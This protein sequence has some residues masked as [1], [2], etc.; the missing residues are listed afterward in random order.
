MRDAALMIASLGD[1]FT[2]SPAERLVAALRGAVT[3]LRRARLARR[4][5]GHLRRL[6][7]RL[8]DDLGLAPADLAA[9]DPELSALDATRRLAGAAAR[10]NAARRAEERWG[11]I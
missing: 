4:H 3:W 10:R 2:A 8:L 11:R 5:L 7:A 1:D 6:D 9:L